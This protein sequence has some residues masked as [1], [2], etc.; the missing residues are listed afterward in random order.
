MT[1]IALWFKDIFGVL[2]SKLGLA[3]ALLSGALLLIYF[4]VK[5]IIDGKDKQIK[6]LSDENKDY[7]DKF[8]VIMDRRLDLGNNNQPLQP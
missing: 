6:S 4:L 8:I 1:Q 3:G 2:E 7:R 5:H